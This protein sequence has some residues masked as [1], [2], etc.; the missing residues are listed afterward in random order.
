MSSISL[1]SGFNLYPLVPPDT[2][3]Q[4]LGISL[5]CLA[6]LNTTLPCD[7]DLM[8]WTHKT[9]QIYWELEDVTT[10]CT[11]SCVSSAETWRQSVETACAN[12]HLRSGERYVPA[13][14]L[15]GRFSEGLN[16]AC[17][18]SSANQWCLLESYEWTGS[19][20]VHVDCEADPTNPWCLNRADFGANQSRMSTL[21]DDDLLC[22][23]CFLKVLH[24]RV[25]SDFL[26]DTDFGDYLVDE[27]QDIQNVCQTTV[28]EL[29][30]RVIPGYAHV[31]DGAEIGRPT[32][33]ASPI[34]TDPTPTSTTCAGRT[35]DVR[36]DREEDLTCHD[37]AEK[38]QIASGDIA[39]ATN[40]EFCDSEAEVCIPSPCDLYRVS[41]ND[42][43]ETIAQSLS[44]VTY[45]VSL[46]QVA[47]W[48][49]NI[50]GACDHLAMGQLICAGP[51]GG[52]WISPPSSEIPDDGD[53]P[54]RGGPG[55]T[56]SLPIINDPSTVPAD[57]VQ[58]GIPSD[59]TRWIVANN[60]Q[61]ACWKLANDAKI[62]MQRLWELNP[63][64]GKSGEHCGTQ[65][66]L[67][68]YYCISRNGDGTDTTPTMSSTVP[69][70]TTQAPK[71]TQTQSGIDPNCNKFEKSDESGD[72]CWGIANRA[73]IEL[74]QLYKWNTVLGTDGE[75]CNTQFWPSYYYCVGVVSSTTSQSPT[76]TVTA[77][78]PTQTQ[79]GFPANCKRWV[80][81]KAGD[82]CWGIGN[83]NGV[84]LEQVYNLNPVL[85]VD[86][87]NC[88]NQMWPGYFYC[89]AI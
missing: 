8:Q 7:N 34:T 12:D 55:S 54:V 53:G 17:M 58:E 16:M 3:S 67:H 51:P 78:L 36:P 82:T 9:D 68:Y 70:A 40:S 29:V 6:A 73:G 21:Y 88:G 44:N 41:R 77:P 87:G 84:A 10:L 45:E 80:E 14:T 47:S 57:K 69:S 23:E 59:C 64:F 43:C 30:T 76:T 65:V 49:P 46:A 63:V 13:D 81:A 85:G 2:M 75:N 5:G 28:G 89:L 48:N 86:G 62:T 39:V 42:T 27:F 83:D 60:T 32:N 56:I 35:I 1:A 22:S 25:T 50:L 19:D 20:V 24:A 61:A 11:S 72:T 26:Q 4:I 37:I 52:A 15:S 79:E 33:T 74:S 31:T 18:R 71:P 38:Y 66:W